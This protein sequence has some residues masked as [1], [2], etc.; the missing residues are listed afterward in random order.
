MVPLDGQKTGPCAE[1]LCKVPSIYPLTNANQRLGKHRWSRCGTT[2]AGEDPQMLQLKTTATRVMRFS[3][4]QCIKE[5]KTRLL[6]SSWA[7]VPLWPD[8]RSVR[9]PLVGRLCLWV[10]PLSLG[11]ERWARIGASSK[12][13]AVRPGNASGASQQQVPEY[14]RSWNEPGWYCGVGVLVSGE[15]RKV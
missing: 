9:W 11:P 4:W 3:F 8:A 5:C 7:V 6:H 13:D 15:R 12:W 10:H 14:G 1:V 2:T